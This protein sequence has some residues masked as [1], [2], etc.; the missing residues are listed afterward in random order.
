[1]VFLYILKRA[2]Q[3]KMCFF[4]SSICSS[5]KSAVAGNG[6]GSGCVCG[7]CLS[8]LGIAWFLMSLSVA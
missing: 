2:S 5:L 6:S 7:G 3:V 1:M 4:Y 8:L